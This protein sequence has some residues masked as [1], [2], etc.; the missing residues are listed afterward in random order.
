[1]FMNK[2]DILVKNIIEEKIKL[3][4]E[5]KKLRLILL[6]KDQFKL[7]EK[8][9][10]ESIKS[11]PWGDSLEYELNRRADCRSE[12]FLGDGSLCGLWVVKVETIDGFELK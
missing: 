9:W 8:D 3:E 2:A 12:I 6:G 10:I 4:K 7:L 11:L 5:G 1:M